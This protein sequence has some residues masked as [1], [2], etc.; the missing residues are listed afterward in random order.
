MGW[1][2]D[3]SWD[4]M[5]TRPH[6]EMVTICECGHCCAEHHVQRGPGGGKRLHCMRRDCKCEMYREY[7]GK[8]R[9]GTPAGESIAPARLDSSE[10][11]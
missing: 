5:P 11:A 1:Y 8:G 2:D 7:A 6:P 10:A 3:A 9:E 4:G